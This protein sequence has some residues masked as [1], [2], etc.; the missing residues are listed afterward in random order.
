MTKFHI[1]WQKNPSLTPTDPAKMIQLNLSLLEMVKAEL[2]AG[3]LTDW[4]H[5]CNGSSGYCIV[6]GTET[7][8][9]PTLLKY[10]P[11]ILFDVKPVISVDQSIEANKL[12][13]QS[14]TK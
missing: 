5:Y 3:R 13:A 10:S 7:D 2:K 8:M 9:V 14:K 12:A 4:G 11:Y 6:E 1:E